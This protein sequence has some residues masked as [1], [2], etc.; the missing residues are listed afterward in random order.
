MSAGVASLAGPGTAT[1]APTPET[2]APRGSV[3][4]LLERTEALARPFR[5][6][7]K[8]TPVARRRPLTGTTTTLPVLARARDGRGATWLRV[9]LPGRPNGRTGWIPARVTTR[10]FLPWRIVVTTSTRRVEA[11][12]DGKLMR[13]FRGVVGAAGTPTPAGRFFVEES[14]RLGAGEV[15]GPY[16]LALSARSTVLQRF[17][18]GPGQIALHGMDN[19]GG[20]PGTAAS[21]G[22][23]RLSTAAISWLAVRVRPGTRVTVLRRP[24]EPAPS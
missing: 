3:A 23:V 10:G 15:G 19:V 24:A 14:V 6:S 5:G 11:Y 21:H 4:T 1:A 22:C 12:Y 7:A 13:T 18:G 2:A 16:A 20:V 9:L 17:A 8:V